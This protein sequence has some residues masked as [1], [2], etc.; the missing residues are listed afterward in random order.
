MLELAYINIILYLRDEVLRE[1][2]KENTA[3]GVWLKLEQLH[4]T[5]TLTNRVYLK[6]RLFGFRMTEDES[7]DD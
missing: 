3:P 2:A 4:I 7:L 1:V 6:G 5:K